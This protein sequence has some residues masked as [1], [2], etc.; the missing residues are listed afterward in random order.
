MISALDFQTGYRGFES[1]SGRDNAHTISTPGSYST[2]PG[3]SIKWTGRH[4]ATDSRTKCAWVIHESKATQMQMH[5][6]NNRRC[7]HEPRVPGSVFCTT[8]S[9]GVLNTNLKASRSYAFLTS[10]TISIS[11][12]LVKI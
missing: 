11:R 10:L 7:L 1:R 2:C 9:S 4:L 12:R 3:L 6:H 8:P 5:V